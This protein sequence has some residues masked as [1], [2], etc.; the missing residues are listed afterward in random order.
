MNLFFPVFKV[1]EPTFFS[2]TH[3]TLP[4]P[5]TPYTTSYTPT[6]NSTETTKA[7]DD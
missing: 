6:Q 2:K 3:P 5:H 4:T 7:N 1:M